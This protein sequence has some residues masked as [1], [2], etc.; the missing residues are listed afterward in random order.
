MSDLLTDLEKAIALRLAP[1]KDRGL[2]VLNS[3]HRCGGNAR[4]IALFYFTDQTAEAAGSCNQN[5]DITLKL[6]IQA[7]D[8]R[9]HQ[10][11]YPFVEAADILL[12]E[13]QPGVG[14]VGAL[15]FSSVRYVPFEDK[16]GI[17][18]LYD[19][20]FTLRQ[21]RCKVRDVE[22]AIADTFG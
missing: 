7:C 10:V 15:K 19:L 14:K 9:S 18:W 2:D 4:A 5:R 12:H 8:Q 16:N 20:T 6:E 11:A 21:T 3:P 17:K 22:R 13:Y 1:L